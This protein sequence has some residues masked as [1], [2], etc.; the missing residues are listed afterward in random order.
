MS[1][2]VYFLLLT[3]NITFAQITK[4]IGKEINKDIYVESK[5]YKELR[6][7]IKSD[8]TVKK[9]SSYDTL[10]IEF[11]KSSKYKKNQIIEVKSYN[12]EKLTD[13]IIHY[14]FQIDD[15]TAV[16]FVY[17]K[18]FDFDSV[19]SYNKSLVLLKSKKLLK[20]D[21]IFSINKFIKKNDFQDTDFLIHVIYEIVS[22]KKIIFLL[23]KSD[24][25][26]SKLQIKQVM[27]DETSNKL[28][29]TKI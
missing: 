5:E 15:S 13:T 6:K 7:K 26:G 9:F 18:Y 4:D 23:D 29:F 2:Y 27:L 24:C 3:F 8:E 16:G 21:R 20:D 12:G 14:N 10:F 11:K 17:K 1:K 28:F 22:T 19:D 25:L